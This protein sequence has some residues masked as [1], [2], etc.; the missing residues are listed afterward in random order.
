MKINRKIEWCRIST[1]IKNDV[2]TGI[3]QSVM[4]FGILMIQG[5]VNTFGTSIM[6]AFTAAVKIDT[7]AYMPAQE[8]GNAYSLFIFQNYGAKKKDRIYNGTK[9]A[10]IVSVL[11]CAI[12]SL[13]IWLFSKQ[14]MEMFIAS[15]EK[16]LF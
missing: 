8:F 12:I 5:L 9:I 1:I 6:A 11:F 14:F 4:N 2:L 16:I 13:V 7:L 15:T 3:Q 10:T